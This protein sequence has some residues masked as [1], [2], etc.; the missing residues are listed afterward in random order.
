MQATPLR[1]GT[2]VITGA[3]RGI[4]AGIARAAA[5]R[6]M[7]LML[8]D[9]DADGLE[10]MQAELSGRGAQVAC[11][12]TD[13]CDPEALDRLAE[14]TQAR[15][16]P[17]RLLVNNA[18]VEMLGNSWELSAAQW[19]LAIRLNVLGPI[20][21]VRAFAPRMIAAGQPARIVNIASIAAM[22]QFPMQTAYIVSKH[23]VLSFSECL[24]LEMQRSAPFV[25][26][27]AV[28]PGPVATRIFADAPAA[29][30]GRSTEHHRAAMAHV[31]AGGMHPDEAGRTILD[32]AEEGRFWIATHP[33]MLADAAKA[34]ASY[35][36][37]LAD[38]ALKPGA[39]AA[40]GEA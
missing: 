8:A 39:E 6:G 2:A 14:T 21:G 38:P 4:G 16:G 24:Y 26:V 9:I 13:V 5:A 40:L 25:G 19:E 27:S 3:A 23:A 37:A 34:R 1:S 29:A 32:Q 35:L 20:Q 30:K 28:L 31:V 10:R 12:P 36:S 7:T 33:D 11:T 17:V 22:A 15:F 18:G